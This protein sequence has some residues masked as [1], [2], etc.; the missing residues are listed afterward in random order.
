MT[1]SSRLVPTTKEIRFISYAENS[2]I[3]TYRQDSVDTVGLQVTDGFQKTR[4]CLG[5]HGGDD[6]C[7]VYVHQDGHNELHK[8]ANNLGL[9]A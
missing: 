7:C 6:T 9:C 8:P 2:V 4:E 3:S 1:Q 5:S